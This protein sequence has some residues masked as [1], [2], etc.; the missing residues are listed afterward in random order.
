[1]ECIYEDSIGWTGTI[2]NTGIFYNPKT[3]KPMQIPEQV[4][5]LKEMILKYNGNNPDYEYVDIFVDSG[6]CGGGGLLSD[7][8][9][10]DWKD[11]L[12]K[13]HRGFIDN[14]VQAEYKSVFPNAYNCLHMIAPT[15]YKTLMFDA[16]VDYLNLGIY[17]FVGGYDNKETMILFK[18]ENGE[19]VP[20]SYELSDDEINV[21][22]NVSLMHEELINMYQYKGANNSYRYD[23][24]PDKKNKNYYDDRA[25]VASLCAWGLYLLKK[26]DTVDRNISE[27]DI[28]S[29]PSCISVIDF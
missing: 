25:Y 10:E 9:L 11:K 21:Y 13:T 18:T 24:A 1:M 28:S 4:K 2:V 26:Q 12:G 23:L 29:A 5:H 3:K 17:K 19:Q 6:S 8:F 27:L 22:N 14:D 20:Y 15:K 7:Y 16:L